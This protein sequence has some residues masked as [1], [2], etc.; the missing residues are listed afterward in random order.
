M[1][2]LRLWIYFLYIIICITKSNS[3]PPCGLYGQPPCKFLPAQPGSTPSC[4]GPGDTYCVKVKDY[5]GHVVKS[6]LQRY[7]I[8]G[9]IVDETFD[10][11][12]A[13]THIHEPYHHQSY[14]PP[15][16]N[17][18]PLQPTP[19]PNTE[20]GGYTYGP[21]THYGES[22]NSYSQS[23][24]SSNSNR[25]NYQAHL[26]LIFGPKRSD[27][28]YYNNNNNYNNRA[29]HG[30]YRTPFNYHNISSE[31][32]RYPRSIK[33]SK[34]NQNE[35]MSHNSRT[36]R[37]I[38]FGRE[39]LCQVRTQ[40]VNPQAALNTQGNWMYVINQGQQAT[41]LVKTEV[42]ASSICSN[43]CQLPNGY[44]SRC[45][46]KYV[47]KRLVALETSGQR[48]YTDTFWFPS[49]CVCTLSNLN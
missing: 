10:E 37:Q 32:G 21:R 31:Y 29:N 41:Q 33:K 22:A 35:T 39:Q 24:S 46:Q 43:L 7:D 27:N 13:Y 36:K 4:A 9:M 34:I 26:N 12:H 14:G 6:L 11:F 16:Y 40:F 3:S 2:E 20:E 30:Y 44:N 47:Q 5:P 18:V 38:A 42:C 23:S 49:C 1:L 15:M 28:R 48:L 8:H 45:E 19:R 17:F 25:N